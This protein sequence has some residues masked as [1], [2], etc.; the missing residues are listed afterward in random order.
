MKRK[1]ASKVELAAKRAALSARRVAA[2][3]ADCA[4]DADQRRQEPS[5]VAVGV[6]DPRVGILG[7]EGGQGRDVEG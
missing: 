1:R 4:E 5:G 7:E 6:H 2:H 3:E